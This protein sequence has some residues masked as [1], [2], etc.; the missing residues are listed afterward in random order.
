MVIA[1]YTLYV[2]KGDARIL[3][4]IMGAV[5]LFWITDAYYLSLEREYRCLFDR[6]RNNTTTDYSMRIQ[7][8]WCKMFKAMGSRVFLFSYMPIES[9]T[10]VCLVAIHMNLN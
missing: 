3:M 1:L 8:D 10:F 2:S 5:L 4:I 7:P 6:V 9:L